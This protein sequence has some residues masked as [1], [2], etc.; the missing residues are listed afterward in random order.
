RS[1]K[2][3]ICNLITFYQTK[4]K[5]GP[6]IAGPFSFQL[7]WSVS[8]FNVTVSNL[9][10]RDQQRSQLPQPMWLTFN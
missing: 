5:K 7:K 2:F 4:H 10:G 1:N 9:N 3:L 8:N 6:A